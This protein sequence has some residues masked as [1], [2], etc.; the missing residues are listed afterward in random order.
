MPKTISCLVIAL[1]TWSAQAA[2]TG[3]IAEVNGCVYREGKTLSD[4]DTDPA[5][6]T[7]TPN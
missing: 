4:L 6:K 2:D 1:L 5:H 7:R 3:K